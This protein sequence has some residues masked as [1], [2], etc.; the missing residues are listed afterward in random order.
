[1]KLAVQKHLCGQILYRIPGPHR[2]Q[3]NLRL[4][5]PVNFGNESF[6]TSKSNFG[7]KNEIFDEKGYYGQQT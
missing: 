7:K 5:I 3:S 6:Y 2:R 4:N 1:M